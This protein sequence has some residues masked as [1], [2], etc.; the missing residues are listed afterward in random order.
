MSE[1]KVGDT[2]TCAMYGE[3]KVIDVR[4]VLQYGVEVVFRG[5]LTQSYSVDGRLNE[6]ANRTLFKGI[7]T[8]SVEF[9]SRLLVAILPTGE[10]AEVEG[11]DDITYVNL[12]RA[13]VI[14]LS[15]C[16]EQVA[17]SLRSCESDEEVARILAEYA[18]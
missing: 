14:T 5:G 7:V 10:W 8:F 3:G 2:V 12:T 4:D 9:E 15:E 17:R 16:S 11:A 18:A 1:F 13:Q 6:A